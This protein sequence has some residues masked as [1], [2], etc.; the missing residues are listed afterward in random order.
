MD[1]Q[2]PKLLLFTDEKIDRDIMTLTKKLR[3][4]CK[5]SNI[6]LFA[7]YNRE[8]GINIEKINKNDKYYKKVKKYV[9]ELTI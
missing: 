6:D 1:I 7:N 5:N 8:N 2:N 3:D 4:K 9:K